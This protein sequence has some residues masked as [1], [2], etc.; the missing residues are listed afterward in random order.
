MKK[1]SINKNKTER[2][3]ADV[4]KSVLFYNEWFLNFAP[5]TYINARKKAINKVEMLSRRL[6][7]LTTYPLTC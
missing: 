3:K 6:N 7:A 4:Q 1:Y 5:D 2:W